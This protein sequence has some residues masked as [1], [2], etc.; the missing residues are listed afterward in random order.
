MNRVNLVKILGITTT[1]I[2]GVATLI[3]GWVDEQKMKEEVAE[4]TKNIRD[5]L[6]AEVDA[7]LKEDEEEEEES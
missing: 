1:I 2:G 5:E 4:Q 3:G 6:M 7:R